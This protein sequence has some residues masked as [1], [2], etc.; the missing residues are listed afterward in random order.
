MSGQIFFAV[1]TG[2]A[3]AGYYLGALFGAV[4]A[5]LLSLGAAVGAAGAG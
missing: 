5:K 1:D 2:L 3:G 4:L